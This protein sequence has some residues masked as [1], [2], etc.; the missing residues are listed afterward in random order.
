[1][2]I[3]P[4]N[5]VSQLRKP[6]MFQPSSRRWLGDPTTRRTVLGAE[7]LPCCRGLGTTRLDRLPAALVAEVLP[8]YQREV[9]RVQPWLHEQG[10]HA[11][12]A[13]L[14][15]LAVGTGFAPRRASA[16]SS[17]PAWLPSIV[18]PVLDPFLDGMRSEVVPVVTRVVASSAAG[19]AGIGL[20]IGLGL[21]LYL[22]HRQRA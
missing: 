11:G 19:V 22:G 18:D 4:P 14:A 7:P 17:A 12:Q 5:T 8:Y 2:P 13:A 3:V 20:L 15:A 1:M 6:W 9:R 16:P 10:R 21:G